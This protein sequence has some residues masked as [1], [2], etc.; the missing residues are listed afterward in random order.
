M[1]A[2]PLASGPRTTISGPALNAINALSPG[3]Q[4]TLIATDGSTARPYRQW[5]YDLMERGRSGKVLSLDIASGSVRA[6]VSSGCF[7]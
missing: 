3:P 1:F 4:G 6:I 7:I 2:T 5:V